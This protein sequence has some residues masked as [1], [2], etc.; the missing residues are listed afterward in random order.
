MTLGTHADR[1]MWIVHRSCCARK[2]IANAL[3]IECRVKT[4]KSNKKIV[5][6]S[7]TGVVPLCPSDDD[8]DRP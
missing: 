3:P 5:N 7:T 1:F 8:D 6:R 4:K 2:H